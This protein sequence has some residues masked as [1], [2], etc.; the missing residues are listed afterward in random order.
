MS[1]SAIIIAALVTIT[2]AFLTSYIL[3]RRRTASDAKYSKASTPKSVLTVGDLVDILRD[4]NPRAEVH[5]DVRMNE[6]G[7]AAGRLRGVETE[8]GDT[9][10]ARLVWLVS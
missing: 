2:T 8:P 5:L 4:Y 3:A 10:L 1:I 7:G 9:R 6:P